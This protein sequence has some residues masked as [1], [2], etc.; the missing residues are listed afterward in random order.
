MGTWLTI[1]NV[2]SAVT[3]VS[4]VAWFLTLSEVSRDKLVI[5]DEEG[6]AAV[7][8]SADTE[9]ATISIVG[10]SGEVVGVLLVDDEGALMRL[11]GAGGRDK[12][13]QRVTTGEAKLELSSSR[14]DP[15]SQIAMIVRPD[16]ALL[17]LSSSGYLSTTELGGEGVAFELRGPGGRVTTMRSDGRENRV[18]FG[19]EE[20]RVELVT[21]DATA[22]V[23]LISDDRRT[24]LEVG[25]SVLGIELASSEGR[26]RIGREAGRVHVAQTDARGVEI[27][28]CGPREP[29]P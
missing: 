3:A 17:R 1:V 22:R 28:A 11:E 24:T 25:P 18:V 10:P 29:L 20:A 26:L 15:G 13:E 6:N 9:S 7:T 2:A 16:E 8:L 19:D 12:I 23:L 27:W 5:T 21:G 14:H 4:V